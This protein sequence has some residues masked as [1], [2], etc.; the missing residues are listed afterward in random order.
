MAKNYFTKNLD[1]K[2][3]YEIHIENYNE[4]KSS[5]FSLIASHK[6]DRTAAFRETVRL[7]V[8]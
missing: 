5:R 7:S 6:I 8:S 3:S 1:F 4:K 2:K